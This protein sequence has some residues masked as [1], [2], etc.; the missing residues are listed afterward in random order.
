MK[1]LKEVYGSGA[2]SIKTVRLKNPKKHVRVKTLQELH[3]Y[4]TK[5]K[6]IDVS[7]LTKLKNFMLVIVRP[8]VISTSVQS[9]KNLV[10]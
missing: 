1:K 2:G 7:G 3:L 4:G 10:L 6:S 8:S 5:I 9:L